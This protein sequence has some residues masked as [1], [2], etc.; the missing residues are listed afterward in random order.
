LAEFH[1]GTYKVTAHR[2]NIPGRE[3][4]WLIDTPGFDD[5]YR[6]DGEILGEIANFLTTVYDS[7]ILL[8]GII[9]LHRIQD[10]R[11]GNA[12]LKNIRTFKK[13]CGKDGLERT[14]LVTTFWQGVDVAVGQ[15]REQELLT[16]PEL[17]KVIMEEGSKAFRYDLD[18]KKQP[19][20]IV[21]HIV[22]SKLGKARLTIQSEMGEQNLKLRETEAGKE[23]GDEIV[24]LKAFYERQVTELKKQLEDK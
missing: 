6:S 21:Q 7:Q 9:Y 23:V 15:E 1:T 24:R 18:D 17:W 2:C 3:R 16:T 20:K 5:T 8:T 10:P 13:L 4:I 22:E 19:L 12:V 14:I 11:A